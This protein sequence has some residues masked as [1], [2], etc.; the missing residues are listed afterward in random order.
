MNCIQTFRRPVL[1][2][3]GTWP[4][5][6]DDDT[7][8]LEVA[9]PVFSAI[10]KGEIESIDYSSLESWDQYWAD[11]FHPNALL[12]LPENTVRLCAANIVSYL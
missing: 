3:D 6:V 10:P 2:V 8:G 4:V 9:T 7:D 11:L 12:T 1:S 5:P